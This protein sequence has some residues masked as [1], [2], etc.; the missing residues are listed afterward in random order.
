MNRVSAAASGATCW[1]SSGAGAG[2]VARASGIGSGVCGRGSAVRGISVG[3]TCAS[4][5]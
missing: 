1:R 2:A 3:V 5:A 4:A